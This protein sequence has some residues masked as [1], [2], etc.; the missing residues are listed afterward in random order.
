MLSGISFTCFTASYALGLLLEIGRTFRQFGQKPWLVFAA[1]LAGFFAHSVYI[2]SRVQEGIATRG[3]PLSNWYHWCLVAA[4]M[5]ALIYLL[6]VAFRPENTFGI[7]LLP[8]ILALLGVAQTFPKDQL[9]P[10]GKATQVWGMFHGLGLLLGTVLVALG[11]VAGAMYLIQSYRLKHKI[12]G[13]RSERRGL[14]LPSLEWLRG[15]NERCLV[16]STFLLVM[17]IFAGVILNLSTFRDD[18]RVITMSNPVT[19]ISGLLLTWLVASTAF[20]MLYKPAREGRKVAYLTIT[21]F[22]VLVVTLTV[23]LGPSNHASGPRGGAGSTPSTE[24][25]IR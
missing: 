21:S 11:F 9:F 8:I 1:A 19:W 2:A 3:V 15:A 4:W 18:Q 7:F 13:S 25:H 20:V 12:S 5:L 10:T 14:R 16:W 22:V 23:V 6:L 17:G 24:S